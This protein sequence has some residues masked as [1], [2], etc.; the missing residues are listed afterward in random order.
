MFLSYTFLMRI[1]RIA[2]C[3][4]SSYI[5]SK[6]NRNTDGVSISVVAQ[7]I[8]KQLETFKR[9]AH[10]TKRKN[11]YDNAIR[12]FYVRIV[13]FLIFFILIYLSSSTTIPSDIRINQLYQNGSD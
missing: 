13:V 4:L 9:E 8:I 3:R 11:S 12:R 6:T 10:L 5:L 2:V 1:Q 7:T